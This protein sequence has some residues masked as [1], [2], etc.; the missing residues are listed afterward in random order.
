MSDKQKEIDS[1]QNQIEEL[2]A[3]LQYLRGEG[4]ISKSRLREA[5]PDRYNYVANHISYLARAAVSDVKKSYPRD[6]QPVTFRFMSGK[7]LEV[8]TEF[9]DA[10]VTAYEIARSKE[11]WVAEEED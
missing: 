9:A 6:S 4:A 5:D 1:I 2:K 7:Q 11:A 8:A 10:V 3:Q